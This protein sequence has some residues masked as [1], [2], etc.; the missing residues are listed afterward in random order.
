MRTL[1]PPG[2]AATPLLTLWGPSP[3]GRLPHHW[4]AIHG[5]HRSL[6]RD[7]AVYLLPRSWGCS[8]RH[9]GTPVPLHLHASL[10]PQHVPDLFP[11]DQEMQWLFI[12][13]LNSH[14]YL[15]CATANQQINSSDCCKATQSKLLSPG[16]PESG[17]KNS[18]EGPQ[19]IGL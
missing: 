19:N 1:L 2:C 17:N 3:P 7:L 4:P 18:T 12:Q 13:G 5:P 9:T 6:G 14:F 11:T 8:A 16:L 15:I 10:A